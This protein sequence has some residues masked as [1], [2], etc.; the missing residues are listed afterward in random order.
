MVRFKDVWDEETY[1]AVEDVVHERLR[2]ERLWG[3]QNYSNYKWSAVLGEE[4]GE[5][6]KA[7]LEVDEFDPESR[8]ELRRELIQ[9]A[10]VAVAWVEQL[11]R[12]SCWCGAIKDHAD[13]HGLTNV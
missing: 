6:C 8:G 9:V 3:E 4:F 1:H 2:Q 11:D 10:A 13:D 5:A 12:D 7:A